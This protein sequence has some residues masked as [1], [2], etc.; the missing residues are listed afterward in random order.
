MDDVLDL[1]NAVSN[2]LDWLRSAERI[3][4]NLATDETTGAEIG[5][6]EMSAAAD[7]LSALYLRLGKVL[8]PLESAIEETRKDREANDREPIAPGDYH[9]Y[10]T[11]RG[12]PGE[13]TR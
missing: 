5:W 7:E 8:S 1:E 13:A 10:E 9:Y 6:K 12:G 11:P 3:A 4:C 2:A